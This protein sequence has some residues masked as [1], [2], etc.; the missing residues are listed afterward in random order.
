MFEVASGPQNWSELI[1]F[2]SNDSRILIVFISSFYENANLSSQAFLPPMTGLSLPSLILI[3]MD[4]I[5][6]L[7]CHSSF[8]NWL[9]ARSSSVNILSSV[10]VGHS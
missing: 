7:A 10:G 9:A 4:Q 5:E 1:Y 3:L 2:P 6:P 8:Y